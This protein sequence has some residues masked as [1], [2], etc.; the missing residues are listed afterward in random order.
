MDGAKSVTETH[1]PGSFRG[2]WDQALEG[3]ESE[4][5]CLQGVVRRKKTENT[6]AMPWC[7]MEKGHFV[8]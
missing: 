7:F 6:A 3:Q 4:E 1:D 8:V 2:Q 5:D